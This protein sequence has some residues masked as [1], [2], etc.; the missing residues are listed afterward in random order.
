MNWINAPRIKTEVV[1]FETCRNQAAKLFIGKSVGI[2]VAM[3]AIIETR[4]MG[5]ID[6]PKPLPAI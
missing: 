5:I 6:A 3:S 1:Q 4:M 2:P